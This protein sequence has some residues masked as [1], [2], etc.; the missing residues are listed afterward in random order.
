M[1][2]VR[3]GLIVASY[4]LAATCFLYIAKSAMNDLE[5]ILEQKPP[6][7]DLDHLAGA[8]ILSMTA[9]GAAQYLK[10]QKD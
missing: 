10:N 1:S 4:A 8:Y 7:T 3:Y 5:Q 2:V 9:I 6:Q